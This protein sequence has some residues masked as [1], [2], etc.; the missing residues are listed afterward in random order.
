MAFR[1]TCPYC[2]AT[3]PD[4]QESH[5]GQKAKCGRCNQQF[6]AV[7]PDPAAA[8]AAVKAQ[9]LHL[10][11]ARV[12]AMIIEP[13]LV[14]R[15]PMATLRKLS[16]IPVAVS[17][18]DLVV[19]M[20]DPGDVFK[21]DELRRHV[22]SVRPMMALAYEVEQALAELTSDKPATPQGDP[23]LASLGGNKLAADAL[24]EMEKEYDASIDAN[25]MAAQRP[26]AATEGT[27]ARLS[28]DNAFEFALQLG[29]TEIRMLPDPEGK[30]VLQARVET[31]LQPLPC[32]PPCP[33]ADLLRCLK[34]DA[35]L[36]STLTGV[37]QTGSIPYAA[38]KRDIEFYVRILPGR[39]TDM[40]QLRV[41]DAAAMKQR[42]ALERRQQIDDALAALASPEWPPPS[43]GIDRNR[44]KNIVV[45]NI[46]Q[47]LAAVRLTVAVLGQAADSG[48]F[49][50]VLEPHKGLL[51]ALIRKSA[52][53][54]GHFEPML[55]VPPVGQKPLLHRIHLM[56][57]LDLMD[58]D[59]SQQGMFH[60]VRNGVPLET[61]V[62][63]L[64]TEA[65]LYMMVHFHKMV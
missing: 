56:A 40:A 13:S 8:A 34:L 42:R 1:A 21:V 29:A 24:A 32:D 33:Y 60:L 27:P 51:R 6:K 39:G 59:H 65:G 35:G 30:P 7:P 54:G 11:F 9:Q 12:A 15:I 38:G 16:A 5:R 25:P 64:P 23:A 10:R 45:Q 26:R 50:M 37:E 22:G 52:D 62:M 43:L 44:A 2:G 61:R 55:V 48:A 18:N 14:E 53:Q 49:D 41:L 31:A 19:A 28:M 4:I 46:E 47:Q 57:G 17:G 36:N 20:A 3:Y 58:T 63:T